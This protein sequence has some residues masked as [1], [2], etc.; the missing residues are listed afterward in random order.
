MGSRF[1][2]GIGVHT[3]FPFLKRRCTSH[4]HGGG[5]GGRT[6]W[7]VRLLAPKRAVGLGS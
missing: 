7:G 4:V 5:V 3:A 6:L 2:G 1:L